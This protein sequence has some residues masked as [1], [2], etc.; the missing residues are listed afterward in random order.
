M[1]FFSAS[2]LLFALFVYLAFGAFAGSLYRS[3][4]AFVLGLKRLVLLPIDA[5]LNK[6]KLYKHYDKAGQKKVSSCILRNVYDFFFVLITGFVY[7]VITYICLDGVFR[8]YFLLLF[9]LTLGLTLKLFGKALEKAF[10]IFFDSVYN[11]LFYVL[12]PFSI[13]IRFV[14][15]LTLKIA[16]P[17]LNAIKRAIESRNSV[18]LER[19]KLRR[20]E[21]GVASLLS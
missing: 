2:E 1:K 14:A 6:K 13:P 10:V 4:A 15:L 16:A 12:M 8:I 18:R 3:A 20:M 21:I 11:V 7:I 9:A 5:V 19:K 17:P